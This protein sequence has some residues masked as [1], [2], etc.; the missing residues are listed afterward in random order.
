MPGGISGPG[1]MSGPGMDPFPRTRI[2]SMEPAAIPPMPSFPAM[3]M[4]EGYQCSKCNAQL[5][6]L[7]A[8]GSTCPRCKTVWGFKQDE[9]GNKTMT[10]AGRGQLGSVGAIIIVFVLVGTVI[11]IALFV[12]I[13]VAIVKAASSSASPPPPMSQ[14]RYY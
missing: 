4:E 9:F 10:A 8:A 3:Q 7:E 12:G 5:T 11:F 14:Q 13:I 2:P 1:G 6:K